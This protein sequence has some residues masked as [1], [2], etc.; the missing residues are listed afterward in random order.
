MS[1]DSC[2]DVAFNIVSLKLGSPYEADVIQGTLVR[3]KNPHTHDEM[4]LGAS[5]AVLLHELTALHIPPGTHPSPIAFLAPYP[6]PDIATILFHYKH[7]I[8][9][10]ILAH[11]RTLPEASLQERIRLMRLTDAQILTL[12]RLPHHTRGSTNLP[13]IAW[14]RRLHLH[15]IAW[16][17]RLILESLLLMAALLTCLALTPRAVDFANTQIH[18]LSHMDIH[19]F[20][21]PIDDVLPIATTPKEEPSQSPKE[22]A[23]DLWRF[24]LRTI[25]LEDA[26]QQVNQALSKLPL[27]APSGTIVPG[28]IEF[29]FTVPSSTITDLRTILSQ[30]PAVK[31]TLHTSKENPFSWYHIRARHGAIGQNNQKNAHVLIWITQQN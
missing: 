31:S 11:A 24:T 20:K 12:E 29:N 3:M 14:R 22:P 19:L 28:G 6:I 4:R 25:H 8:P 17:L 26:R 9:L 27:H 13:R 16:P 7:A 18:R 5:I 21:E 2:Y 15:S 10:S 1:I 23:L 30:L